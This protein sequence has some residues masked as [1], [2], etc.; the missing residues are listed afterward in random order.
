MAPESITRQLVSSASAF[1]PST[2]TLPEP[3]LDGQS[4]YMQLAAAINNAAVN[5]FSHVSLGAV[6]SLL[7]STEKGKQ[8]SSLSYRISVSSPRSF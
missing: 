4:D 1:N 5:I 7:K 2:S 8:V 3:P 6:S